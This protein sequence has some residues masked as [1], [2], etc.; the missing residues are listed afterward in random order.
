MAA[1]GIREAK[2]I[3]LLVAHDVIER[4]K[5]LGWQQIDK[6]EDDK[7]FVKGVFEAHSSWSCSPYQPTLEHL[8]KTADI[9]DGVPFASLEEVRKWK[10]SSDKPKHR[11]DIKLIDDYLRK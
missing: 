8:L 2:D 5:K 3:D 1:V 4:L 9:I 7:P 10:L 6:G 11:A